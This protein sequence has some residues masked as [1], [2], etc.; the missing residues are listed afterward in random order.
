MTNIFVV[1]VVVKM[2]Y[3]AMEERTNV[4]AGSL[5]LQVLVSMEKY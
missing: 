1:V 3:N 2:K 5:E 4:F